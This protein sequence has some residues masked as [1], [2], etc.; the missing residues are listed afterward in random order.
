[1]R[2]EEIP[3]EARLGV[4]FAHRRDARDELARFILDEFGR[5]GDMKGKKT[6][7]LPYPAKEGK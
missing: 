7:G 6:P 5:R 4:I 2:D 1:M 3:D